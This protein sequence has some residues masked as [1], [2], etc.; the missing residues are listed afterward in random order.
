MNIISRNDAIN[1]G[2][3]EYFTGEPCRRGHVSS[4]YVSN[5]SCIICKKHESNNSERKRWYY[6]KNRTKIIQRQ[7]KYA[8][9]KKKEI[10][11]YQKEYREKTKGKRLVYHKEYYKNNREYMKK[12]NAEYRKC[13]KEYY[14]EM[15]RKYNEN[16][17]DKSRARY[18]KNRDKILK[19]KKEYYG[20][21]KGEFLA[22][23]ALRRKHIRTAKPLWYNHEKVKKIY[24]EAVCITMKTGIPHH[25][26]HIVP[27]RARIACGLHCQENLQVLSAED[28]MRKHNL[29]K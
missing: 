5:Y 1:Q 22:R 15:G 11:A 9:I 18:I 3:R 27:L 8:D 6:L 17:K 19:N 29:F 10:K 7:K 26:D 13:H 4:R 28:N 14:R 16:N 23:N 21:K 25:V 24:E 2:L 20:D 12:Q